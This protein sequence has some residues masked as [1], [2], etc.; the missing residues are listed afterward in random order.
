MREF[1]LGLHH[2]WRQARRSPGFALVA[3]TVLATGIGAS[4][5]MFGLVEAA[6]L[7][8]LPFRDPDRVLWMYNT[9]TERDRAPLSIPDVEDYRRDATTLS[10]LALFTNWTANLTGA[11]LPERLDGTRVSGSFFPLLGVQPWIGRGLQPEDESSDARVVVLTH[12]LWIR[13][14]GGRADIVGRD[15]S[16]SGARY[17][18]V[19]VLPPRFLFPFREAELAV[20]LS[21][22]ADPRRSDRG[23]NFLR[24][25]A[26]LAPGQ[27]VAQAKAQLDGIARRLQRDYPEENARKIGIS[28]YPLHAEIVRDYRTILWTLFASVGVLL[29]AGCGNLA[30]LLLVRAADRQTE[31]AVRLSLGA[32]R[33]RLGRHLL[34]ESAA[35]A[36]AGGLCGIALSV[37]GFQAWRTWGPADFPQMSDVGLNVRV[38]VFALAISAL[39]ALV[40]GAL[41]AMVVARDIAHAVRSMTRSITTGRRQS[42][43]RRTFVGLQVAA[44]TVLLIGMGIA[45]RGFTRLEH[46]TP[47]FTPDRALSVQLS[48]P[49]ASYSTRDAI[50]RFVDAL[51]ERLHAAAGITSAGAVSLLPLSGLLSTMDVAFPER[52]KPR[53]EDV[54]QAHFRVINAEY[55][56]AAGI[57]V[58]DG[59]AFSDRDRVDTQPVA[60]VSRTFAE[61][62]WPGQR[63]VG[64]SVQI[65]QATASAPMAVV[66]VVS[67][68][69]QFTLDAAPTADLYVPVQQMPASQAPQLATRLF[70]I[71]RGSMEPVGMALNLRDAAAHV[72]PA[73]AV[74]NARTLEAVWSASLAPRRANVRL[75]EIFGQ[76]AVVLCALGIYAVAAASARARVR[77]L[78]IRTALGARRSDLMTSMLCREL[79]PVA[80]GAIAG[81]AASL[82]AAP[83]LFGTPYQTSPR[84]ATT[85]VLATAGV[86]ALALIAT[87]LPVRRASATKPAEVL[88]A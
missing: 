52:P 78:A 22:T 81:A 31:F 41:P 40:C 71:V 33:G 3:V 87:Y 86:L 18:V 8:D 10:G 14:F 63:A 72:D 5:L 16:L 69:K 85:Y 25:V 43:V 48:L 59:R 83:L 21:T 68:V 74:S 36:V 67:D 1:L 73:V 82:A 49:P 4:T 12:G 46:V 70:W 44:A 13:R 76:M 66:G 11:G 19:G 80:G 47:G 15:V 51:G 39:T 30:N 62:H 55:L 38:L 45:F 84:D 75:L 56:A 64:R 57:A 79:W 34:G 35:L 29:A 23:A 60:I 24:V 7:R 20:P 88:N 28:L 17:T 65:V 53:P 61:R 6:L 54:P 26:R 50:V 27:S 32:S 42:V 77:E 9:R 37:A 58:L 2:A